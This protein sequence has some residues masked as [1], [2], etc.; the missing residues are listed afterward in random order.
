MS[1]RADDVAEARH[2]P[3]LKDARA[4][5][6][7]LGR[8]RPQAGWQAFSADYSCERIWTSP[9]PPCCVRST[10]VHLSRNACC[11]ALSTWA[12]AL[13][14]AAFMAWQG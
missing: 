10:L 3:E 6:R 9:T 14:L 8:H 5:H 11:I 2:R 12:I 13:E 7:L 1:V 4:L